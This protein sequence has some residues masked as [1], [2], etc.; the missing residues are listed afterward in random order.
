MSNTKAVHLINYKKFLVERG[1]E[2]LLEKVMQQLSGEDRALVNKTLFASEWMDCAL[3][4]RLLCAADRVLGKGDGKIIEEIGAFNARQ[5]LSGIYRIFISIMSPQFLASRSSMIW[6]RYFDTGDMCLVA[7]KA[8]Y[9]KLELVDFSDPP[10]GHEHELIGWIREALLM[11]G[12]KN[13][14]CKHSYCLARNDKNCIFE[15]YWDL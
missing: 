8:N 11:T 15:T 2:E 4:W 9:C 5:D 14:Q 1:G 12:A 6:K 13:V 3:W 7:L 10:L